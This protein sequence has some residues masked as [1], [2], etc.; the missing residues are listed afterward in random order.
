MLKGS[1]MALS[2]EFLQELKSR[3]DIVEVVSQYVNLQRAGRL[4]K[5][6]CPFHHEKTPSFCVYPDTQSVYCFGCHVG[7]EV[8]YFIRKIENLDY[9]DAVKFLAKRAGMDMPE[10]NFQNNDNAVRQRRIYEI[11]RETARFFHQSLTSFSGTEALAYLRGRGLSNKTIRHF[12]LGYAPNSFRLIDYL[13]SKGFKDEELLQANVAHMSKK[14]YLASRFFNRVMFP[15]MDL[16]GNVIA[17]GG[18]IMGDGKPKYLNTADTPVFSK[19]HQLFALNFAKNQSART[20]ILSEGYMDVIALHQA[21]FTN[22]IA[23]LGTSLTQ[24]Q[25]NLI[26]RYAD[27]VVICYD[28]DNAGI[29]ATERAI[30]ILRNTGLKV[31]VLTI[32]GAK[33]PD[34]FMKSHGDKGPSLFKVILEQSVMDIDYRL[35]KLYDKYDTSTTQG[36]IDYLTQA[37]HIISISDNPIE[38]NLFMAKLSEKFDME[39]SSMEESIAKIRRQEKFRTLRNEKSQPLSENNTVNPEKKANHLGAVAEEYI[40]AY[41]ICN[42]EMCQYIN[43]KIREADFVTTFNRKVF[44]FIS[45]RINEGKS[46]ELVFLSQQF[47]EEE[48]AYITAYVSENARKSFSREELDNCINVLKKESSVKIRKNPSELVDEDLRKIYHNRRKNGV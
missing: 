33:D 45:G 11:N 19:S 3:N 20:L 39:K 18:R 22:T 6:R 30:T 24:Q 2:D 21:G 17:F 42:P 10:D 34:E 37:M 8:I 44:T 46:V 26:H 13:K 40:I 32:P 14:G 31:R 28:S 1:I 5:G 15:I 4:Y 38:R 9:I 27:E 12:G 23:T 29:T 36:K 16:R 43:S 47:S 25:A 35:E 48:V 7:G 41:L